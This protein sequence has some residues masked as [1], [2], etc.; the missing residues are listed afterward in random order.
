L[1][2]DPA[3]KAEAIHHVDSAFGILLIVVVFLSNIEIGYVQKYLGEQSWL[4]TFIL[5]F[6][7]AFSIF[8]GFVG[9][10]RQSIPWRVI[11]WLSAFSLLLYFPI[12]L[13]FL[14]LWRPDNVVAAGLKLNVLLVI[15]GIASLAFTLH[16]VVDA[17]CRSLSSVSCQD[18]LLTFLQSNRKYLILYMVLP[19][20]L[21]LL[22]MFAFL[23]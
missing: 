22:L 14:A 9:I 16:V 4:I 1:S 8:I 2:G 6:L 12:L 17:Y 10:L 7:V 11:G 23:M 19:L 20:L 18:D 21:S 13:G 15:A 3:L 5:A